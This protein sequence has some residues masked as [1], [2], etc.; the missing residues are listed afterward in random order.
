MTQNGL[1]L[2]VHGQHRGVASS[3]RTAQVS[4]GQHGRQNELRPFHH[5][6]R[7]WLQRSNSTDKIF[8]VLVTHWGKLEGS[9]LLSTVAHWLLTGRVCQRMEKTNWFQLWTPSWKVL[10]SWV[11]GES[12]GWASARTWVPVPRTYG[13]LDTVVPAEI[14]VL[15]GWMEDGD[16]SIPRSSQAS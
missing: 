16:Q 4:V 15:L 13:E 6:Q 10:D 2:A 1:S 9:H 12:A 5:G 7:V 8:G 11:S 3:L 14:S